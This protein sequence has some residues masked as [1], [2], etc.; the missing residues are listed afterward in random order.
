MANKLTTNSIITPEFTLCYPDLFTPRAA[1]GSSVLKYSCTAVFPK[2]TDLSALKNLAREA[3]RAK[4]PNGAPTNLF[5]PFRDGDTDAKPEW[6]EVFKGSI[7]IRFISYANFKDGSPRPAPSV[8]DRSCR[9]ITDAA[10]I[11]PGMK[12]RAYVCAQ[13]Y[14]NQTKGIRFLLNQIQ[15]VADGERL[16]VDPNVPAFDS[17]AGADSPNDLFDSAPAPSPAAVPNAAGSA[18][19]GGYVDPFA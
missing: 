8:F 4:W 14:D 5:N 18:P 7:F 6:G 19:A 15:I 12:A 13:G 1:E 10:A 16:G 17:V 2:G 11:Y 3:L 9:R